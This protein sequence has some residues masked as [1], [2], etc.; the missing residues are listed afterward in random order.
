MR[1]VPSV[2]SGNPVGLIL[3]SCWAGWL[4]YDKGYFEIAGKTKLAKME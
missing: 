4:K 3:A 2:L 1:T